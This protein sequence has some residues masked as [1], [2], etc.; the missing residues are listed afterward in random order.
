MKKLFLPLV[1]SL[2]LSCEKQAMATATA[3]ASPAPMR[4]PQLT[5]KAG[6]YSAAHVPTSKG[7]LKSPENQDA[8]EI[9]TESQKITPRPFIAAA[10]FDGHGT[11]GQKVAAYAQTHFFKAIEKHIDDFSEENLAQAI[12]DTCQALDMFFGIKE[13]Y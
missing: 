3:A 8:F 9:V 2:L 6:G 5:V 7:D 12:K 13:G 1:V 10:V 4:T 11:E